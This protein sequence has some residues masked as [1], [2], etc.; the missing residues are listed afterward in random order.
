MFLILGGFAIVELILGRFKKKDLI[1]YAC[2]MFI[3][4]IILG[5]FFTPVA[6]GTLP[7]YGIQNLIQSYASGIAI[8][9]FIFWLL[10][11]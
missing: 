6:L 4:F 5:I 1:T 2:W 3:S 8:F 10:I 9:A 11:S 7:R